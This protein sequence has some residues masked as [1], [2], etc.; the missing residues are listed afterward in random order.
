[1][2]MKCI[3]LRQQYGD[4]FKVRY[5]EDYSAEYGPN[6][7]IEAPVYLEIPCANGFI[8]PWSDSELVA[9]TKTAGAVARKLKALRFTTTA[10]DGDDGANV[11]FPV[12]RFE[13][14]AAI[15]KPRRRRRLLLV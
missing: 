8:A 6:A 5:G 2:T 9:C 13:E 10:Q 11:V 4:R 15:M 7:R 12:D 3:N 1:M 14:V